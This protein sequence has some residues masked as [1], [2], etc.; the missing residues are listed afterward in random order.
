MQFFYFKQ[1]SSNTYTDTLWFTLL[2]KNPLAILTSSI[3]INRSIILCFNRKNF[4]SQFSKC[5]V[6]M[7]CITQKSK[8]TVT[9]LFFFQKQKEISVHCPSAPSWIFRLWRKIR[10]CFIL[11]KV[12]LPRKSGANCYSEWT[13]NFLNAKCSYNVKLRIYDKLFND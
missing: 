13:G 1:S 11:Q 5:I 12:L 2:L 4:H 8:E 10:Y 3:C 9:V 7:R 6:H